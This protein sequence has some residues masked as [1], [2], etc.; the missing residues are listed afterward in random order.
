ME[1][2][3]VVMVDDDRSSQS[4]KLGTIFNSIDVQK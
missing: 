3:A 4:P 1:E 2:E